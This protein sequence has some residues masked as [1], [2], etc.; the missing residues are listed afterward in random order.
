[1]HLFKLIRRLRQRFVNKYALRTLLEA[2]DRLL[3][4]IGVTRDEVLRASQLP[5]WNDPAEVIKRVPRERTL[6]ESQ[7]PPPLYPQRSWTT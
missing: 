2:D 4:D 5:F 7:R 1:M 3:D 6:T